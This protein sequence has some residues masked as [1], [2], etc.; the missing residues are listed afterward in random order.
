MFFTKTL[1]SPIIKAVNILKLFLFSR[2]LRTV[3]VV[4][5]VLLFL[6]AE[7]AWSS[8]AEIRSSVPIIAKSPQAFLPGEKLT[9]TISWSK[10]INAGTAV[11]EVKK[12]QLGNGRQALRFVSTAKS[13]GVVDKF[14]QVRDV[15]QSVFDPVSRESLEYSLDQSHGPRKKKRAL[16]FDHE[17]GTVVYLSDGVR[18]VVD[19]KEQTQD[20]LSSVYYLRMRDDFI[21][22]KSIVM[23]IHDS[24]KNWSVEIQVL[25]RERIS[26]P[27]GT[28][29]TIKVK[30]Y[31]KY[32]GVFMHKGEIFMWLTDD[33]RRIPVLMKSTITI[34]SI[35]AMLTE[36]KTGE[37][38]P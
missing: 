4:F 19:I 34:G 3:S 30:T 37:S 10:V 26:T 25:G 20:A 6:P 15:V 33:R 35:V 27:V 8:S 1:L 17:N 24:G 11:M 31:P 38:V 5:P 36:M 18:E 7:A 28:F 9:Y 32:E 29:D 2:Y 22:G 14:Y 13:I 12:E 21:E 16:R 23:D